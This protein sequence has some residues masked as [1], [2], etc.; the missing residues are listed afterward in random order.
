MPVDEVPSLEPYDAVVLGSAVYMHRWW[1]DARSFLRRHADELARR[2]PKEDAPDEAWVE[3]AKV[4]E[5][6]EQ[7]GARGHVVFGGS[8]PAEP[9]GPV[10]WAM[11]KAIPSEYRDLRDWDEIRDWAAGITAELQAAA[12]GVRA[13][14]EPTG[15]R[16]HLW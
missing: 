13:S 9:H 1:S 16:Q 2:P 11:A 10:D 8:V 12:P 5:A 15:R 4:A 6:A 7:L 14:S 3:P